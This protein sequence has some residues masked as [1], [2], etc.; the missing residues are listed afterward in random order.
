MKPTHRPRTLHASSERDHLQPPHVQ[1]STY[2]QRRDPHAGR[3]ERDRGVPRQRGGAGPAVGGGGRRR[4]LRRRHAG[5]GP[6]RDARGGRRRLGPRAGAAD[7]RGCPGG[8]GRG[9]AVS[10]RRHAAPRRR[11]R[12]RAPRAVRPHG[13][14]R[15]L[16][17]AVRADL[18]VVGAGRARLHAALG[19]AACGCGGIASPSATGGLFAHRPAFDARR[20]LPRAA[21]VRRPR[22]CPRAPSAGH[23]RV[24]RRRRRDLG[25]GGSSATGR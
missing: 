16:P 17:N 4:R 22:L 2:R 25:G 23:V 9:A 24:S 3:G 15:M 21:A 20:G 12:R 1:P 19:G 10:A 13:R 8:D 14:G 11:A 18:R 5:G 6:T 7:E